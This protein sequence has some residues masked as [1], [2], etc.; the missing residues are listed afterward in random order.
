MRISDSKDSSYLI[1]MST[2]VIILNYNNSQDTIN[3]IKSVEKYNTADIKYIIVDNGS[4]KGIVV[5]EISSFLK[6]SFSD[7][8]F[9]HDK[10]TSPS[11]LPKMTFLISERNEGY[12]EGNNKGLRLAYK[13]ESIDDVL[14]LN[15]DILFVDDIIP[16]MQS[17]RATLSDCAIISPILYKKDFEDIDYNCARKNH[18]EWELIFTYLFLYKDICG[19]ISQN[20]AKRKLFLSNPDLQKEDILPIELPSGSC[21]LV[22]KA[23]MNKVGGFDSGT[24]LY[25]EENI[26]FKKIKA[27]GLRNYLL[28]Q[29]KCIHL[30][31][32]STQKVAGAFLLKCSLD[33]ASHYLSHYCSLSILQKMT[34]G[35]SRIL[36]GLKIKIVSLIK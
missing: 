36:F 29:C 32:T 31:A 24:F 13:D 25:F 16:K 17:V 12:G 8:L 3:C 19:F 10:E 9:L 18:K 22:S 35:I 5:E 21:M 14:I 34:W 27:L 30:G 33:S 11:V 4:T 15:T 23:L 28:P 20:E 1:F 2:A 7:V 6:E 26:L